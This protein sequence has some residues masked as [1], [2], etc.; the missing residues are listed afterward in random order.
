MNKSRVEKYTKEYGTRFS[1]MQ[2]KRF[3]N[4]VTNDFKALG[5]ES[6][7][8]K[9]RKLI[10]KV[11]NLLFG[12]LKSAKTIIVLPYDTPDRKFWHK[13]PYFP[14]DGNKTASKSLAATYVPVLILYVFLMAGIFGNKSISQDPVIQIALSLIMFVLLLFVVYL[15][16][17]GVRNTKNYNRNSVA[18]A[19]ALEIAEGIAKDERRKV[20]FLFTDKNRTKAFGA[21][22]AAKD[23]AQNGKNPNIIY[24]D[25]IGKG[26]TTMIG[27]NP[28]NKK[29][30]QEIAKCAP[31]KNAISIVK[32][33]ENMR[34]QTALLHFKK[35]VIVASG[36]IDK[37]GSLRV[38]GTSTGKD[39][40]VD[41][42]R[43]DCVVKSISTYLKQLK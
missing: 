28:Q 31:V 4:E 10:F 14:L 5:Y 1:S 37:D 2:K 41:E 24:L 8:I 30:A 21:E 26:D 32:M 36:D 40:Q 39:N 12:N 35:A 23:F 9:G 25:C 34:M 13:V 11:E 22:I 38:M 15:V 16:A 29:M 33:E 17:H 20:A 43:V 3:I 42:E 6:T 27:F 18:I 7:I 19:A